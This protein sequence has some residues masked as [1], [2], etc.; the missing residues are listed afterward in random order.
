MNKFAF[1]ALL[2]IG[3]AAATSGN[4]EAAQ[5]CN[6]C[7]SGACNNGCITNADGCYGDCGR[8]GGC[9]KLSALRSRGCNGACGG[10]NLCGRGG[11]GGLNRGCGPS[12]GGA[13]G[14]GHPTAR[15]IAR[16]QALAYPWHCNYYHVEW[17]TPVA[18]VVPPTAERQWE[19][20]WGVSNSRVTRIWHQFGRSY[21][22]EAIDGSGE[23]FLATPVFP[24]DT[25]QFGV[26]YVR[27]PW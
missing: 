5:P 11:A 9:G 4:A 23:P 10:G 22:G 26:Y 18:L 3:I 24:S 20:G 27:G 19:L 6:N 12:G 1:A 21:P 25:S 7:N 17:G 16:A 2:G 8:C 14:A 13:L 15:E